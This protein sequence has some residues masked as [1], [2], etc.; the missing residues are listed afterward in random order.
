MKSSAKLLI[1]L[2]HLMNLIRLNSLLFFATISSQTPL[3]EIIHRHPID[4]AE[5]DIDFFC[6]VAKALETGV[7]VQLVYIN[8][9][10]S[11]PEHPIEII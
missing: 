4:L 2:L 3:E 1:S 10:I 8:V 9:R 11:S 6:N 5:I 7:S